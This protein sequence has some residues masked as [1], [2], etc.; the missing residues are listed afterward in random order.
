LP[1]PRMTALAFAKMGASA[2]SLGCGAPGGVFGPIFF[3]GAMSGGSF[4]ALSELLLPG[5]TG[6]RGSYAL[7]GL[8]A[9]LAATTHAPLTA[10]FL[11]FE[12]T[13][14]YNVTVPALITAG[15]GL[16]VA[17]RLEPESIDTFGLTL[18]GKSL[19][20]ASDR[21]ML[22]RIPIASVYRKE[23]QAIAERAPVA[24]VL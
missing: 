22:D 5:L 19:H 20:P 21:G 9:F 18:E 23:V 10:I 17:T 1:W 4:R 13:Q 2:L 11:L 24:E 15:L 6:P 16:M 8:G 7:V 14:D 12:M 3:I